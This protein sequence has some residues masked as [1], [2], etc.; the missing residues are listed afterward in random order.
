VIRAAR[1]LCSRTRPRELLSITTRVLHS[2]A[3]LGLCLALCAAIVM[4]PARAL[5]SPETLSRSF[6][7]IVNGPLDMLLS[8]ITGILTL[9]TNIQDIDDSTAVRV[10]YALPGWIWLTGLNF[11]AGGIRTITGALE[12]IPGVLLY[13]FETDI[14]P[15]F[16][17]VE[18]AAALVDWDNP[19]ADTENPWL[20]YNP[21]YTLV[22]IRFKFGIDYTKA[23]Y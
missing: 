4:A 7:N 5:A 19:L 9:A 12:L 18:D 13:P 10:V 17:P 14:D 11:G 6:S 1:G 3:T 8:P 23:D 2:T 15:L 16:D 21:L 20:L 22:S